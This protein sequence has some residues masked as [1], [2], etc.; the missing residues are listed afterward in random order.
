MIGY[1][2]L[3]IFMILLAVISLGFVIGGLY[4]NKQ[5]VWIGALCGFVV[6]MLLSVFTGYVY[7][8]KTVSYMASDEFQDR[9]KEQAR[10]MGK[11]WGNTVSG[12]AEG[13]ESTLDEEAIAKAMKKSGR[14]LGSSVKAM[15]SGLDETVG[16][17]VVYADEQ[18]EKSG[19]IL[20]RAEQMRD[21]TNYSYG[22]FLQFNQDYTGKLYLTAYD[23][24][25]LMKDRSEIDISEKKGSGKVHIFK[26]KYFTPGL[27]GY[28]VLTKD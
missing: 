3:F 18:V 1:L 10:T 14:V 11:T 2:L 28:C 5:K 8:K 15:S 21:S 25:H 27:S 6:F 26:Y 19:I 20:G 7:G 24:E 12:A 4:K 17:T 9:T 13:L 23:S 22:L 16:K